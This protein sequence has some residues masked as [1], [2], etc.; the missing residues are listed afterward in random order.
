ML[1]PRHLQHPFVMG[2]YQETDPV[3]RASVMGGVTVCSLPT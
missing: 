3:S 2:Q 1:S